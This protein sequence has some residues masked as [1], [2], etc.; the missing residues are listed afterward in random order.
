[1]PIVDASVILAAI[2]PDDPQH[3]A[4]KAW[5]DNI[6]NSGQHFTVPTILLSEIAAP[7]GRAYN[8]P[9]LA[10]DLVSQLVS[11][12]F[13]KLRVVSIPLAQRAATIAARYKIRGCD[14]IYVALAE[15]MD[16]EL[17]TLDNQQGERAKDIVQ[18][19]QP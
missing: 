7:L 4:S 5:I 16:E 14:A 3:E 11:A 13:S 18:T 9:E 6:V 1:M 8:Q 17:V 2:L 15:A 19:C 10:Q 12:P